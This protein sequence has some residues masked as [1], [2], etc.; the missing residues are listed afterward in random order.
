MDATGLQGQEGGLV[1]HWWTLETS[2][3][4]DDHLLIGQITA[5]IQGRG[6]AALAICCS[7]SRLILHTF[8]FMSTIMY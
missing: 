5:S 3:A 6:V 4:N 8:S 2:S 1:E 7:K